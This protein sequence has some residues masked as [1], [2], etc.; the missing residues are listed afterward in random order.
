[1]SEAK[2]K[3]PTIESIFSLP[4]GKRAELIDGVIYDM[5]PP[6]ATHQR[7]V[8]NLFVDISNHL[9]QK[10]GSCHAFIAPFAVFPEDDETNYVEPDISIICNP[11]K[12]DDQGCHGAPDWIVEVV[13]P[14]SRQLDYMIKMNRYRLSGVRLYWI[15]DPM[16]EL[17]TVYDFDRGE[18]NHYRFRDAIPVALD[19]GW[20]LTVS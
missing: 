17:V 2:Q 11:S 7:I 12:W 19:P 1:L 13:S 14:T 9:R 18:V 6:T 5:A 16:E 4:E 20:S 10:H 3:L 15:V 8:G